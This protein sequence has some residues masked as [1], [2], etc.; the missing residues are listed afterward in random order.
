LA[1]VGIE[2]FEAPIVENERFDARERFEEPGVTA[3]A[4][5]ALQLGE[6]KIQ[7]SRSGCRL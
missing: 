1:R 4:A 3:V 7:R 5:G 2:R 6:P